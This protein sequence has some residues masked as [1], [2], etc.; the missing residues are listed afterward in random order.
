MFFLFQFFSLTFS[1]ENQYFQVTYQNMKDYPITI[2]NDFYI[3]NCFFERLSTSRY[4]YSL[5]TFSGSEPKHLQIFSSAF[6]AFYSSSIGGII[7]AIE[8]NLQ[9]TCNFICLD[10]IRAQKAAF[11]YYIDTASSNSANLD[12]ISNVNSALGSFNSYEF[13]YL[14]GNSKDN[15]KLV[16]SN[17]SSVTTYSNTGKPLYHF[18][19]DNNDLCYCTFEKNIAESH[20]LYFISNAKQCS[21]TIYSCNIIGA[22][23]MNTF[24][25]QDSILISNNNHPLTISN[26]VIIDNTDWKSIFEENADIT[27]HDNYIQ[28]ENDNQGDQPTTNV[29]A[30]YATYQCLQVIS[31]TTPLQTPFTTPYETPYT[32]PLTTPYETPYESPFTTPYTTPLATSSDI[33]STTPSIPDETESSESTSI[34]TNNAQ[35]AT[36]P[37]SEEGSGTDTKYIIIA[38]VLAVLVII[39]LIILFIILRKRRKEEEKEDSSS[40]EAIENS[41]DVTVTQPTEIHDTATLEFFTTTINA[42]SDPFADHFEETNFMDPR[43]LAETLN[44]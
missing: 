22:Q 1:L 29:L 32:T 35:D 30:F 21:S 24:G 27:K 34:V 43:T 12:F 26:S 31:Y 20:I 25:S 4:F 44:F 40:I 7:F 16:H 36:P 23:Y 28:G 3:S 18:S 19:D 41:D 13:I 33:E 42:S 8:A 39:A 5:I 2:E 15:S 14:Q 11:L 9:L 38:V 6:V 17:F 37:V 10:S